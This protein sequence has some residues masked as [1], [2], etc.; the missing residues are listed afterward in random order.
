MAEIAVIFG[1]C[2]ISEGIA[3]ALP[4][5]FPASVISMIL[6]LILLLSGVIKERHIHRVCRFFVGNMAF[7]FIPSCVS[8]LE[9]V[10]T[11]SACLVPFLVISILTTPLVYFVTAKVIQ[12]LMAARRSKEARHG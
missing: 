3:A 9:H 6:L 5:A 2:L 8:I 1:I 4:V 7:F 12:L 11:L 10:Q